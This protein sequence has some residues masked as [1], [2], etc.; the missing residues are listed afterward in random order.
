MIFVTTSEAKLHLRVD[1]ADE[2]ALVGVYITAAEQ[3]AIAL[4]DRGVYADD[5][6]L[7]AAAIWTT[8]YPR[9]RFDGGYVEFIDAAIDFASLVSAAA[10][11]HSDAPFEWAYHVATPF[12]RWAG[13]ALLD[14]GRPGG[15]TRAEAALALEGIIQYAYEWSGN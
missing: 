13:G 6:A 11:R 1:S 2:D 4:L 8:A 3:M 9:R 12:G 7:G 15:V 14:A 10:D 5:T